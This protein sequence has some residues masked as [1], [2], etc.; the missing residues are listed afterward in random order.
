MSC[1]VDY[2]ATSNHTEEFLNGWVSGIY[3]AVP[4]DYEDEPN[5]D[6]YLILG[7][8]RPK[9]APPIADIR[10]H[11]ESL[12]QSATGAASFNRGWICGAARSGI[13]LAEI[14][15]KTGI[16]ETEIQQI[17]IREWGMIWRCRVG[18]EEPPRIPEKGHDG[19]FEFDRPCSDFSE[20]YILFAAKKFLENLCQQRYSFEDMTGWSNSNQ[21]DIPPDSRLET[22]AILRDIR[23]AIANGLDVGM[24]FTIARIKWVKKRCRLCKGRWALGNSTWK[25]PCISRRHESTPDAYKCNC[26]RDGVQ[27]AWSGLFQPTV[28]DGTIRDATSIP[29]RRLWDVVTNRVILFG[30]KVSSLCQWCYD[31]V[32]FP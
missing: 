1:A 22:Q 16:G 3:A 12:H 18:V 11:E 9:F 4:P 14:S 5:S 30:G 21:S 24:L 2:D 26:P 27:T 6:L 23:C 32:S 19:N 10:R 25:V 7:I 13:P 29:P 31:T 15:A 17:V 8:D 28:T 20:D